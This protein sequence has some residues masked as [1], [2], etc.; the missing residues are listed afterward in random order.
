MLGGDTRFVPGTARSAL[1]HRSFRTLFVGAFLSNI[2]TWMQQVVLG[3]F[4]YELT[5]SA[6][7]LG[8]L[9]FAQLGPTLLLGPVS[10]LIADVV[11]RRKLLIGLSVEQLLAAVALAAI[12]STADPSRTAMALVV[13]AAGV[14]NS[15]FMPAYSA[16]LPALV[17]RDDLAGAI[18]LNSAQLNASRVIGPAIGGIAYAAVGPG[19]V[20]LANALS[21]L[22]VIAAVARVAMPAV[23]APDGERGW[24]KLTLGFRVAR[25]DR[26]V[27]RALVTITAFSFFSLLWVGQMPVVAAENLGIDEDSSAYG[28]FYG[29]FG[30]GA[31]VGSLAIGTVFARRSNA[32]LVRVG[33]VV[34]AA[35]LA[36][37][38][39]LRSPTLAYPTVLLVGATYFG[40]ITAL[41]TAMQSRLADNERGRVM[42]LWMMG[43]GGTVALSNL[44]F[45]PVIDRI[46]MRPVMLFGAVVAAVLGWRVAD[47]R[48]PEERDA[49]AVDPVVGGAADLATGGAATDAVQPPASRAAATRSSPA[50]R[51]ALIRTASPSPSA[52]NA[53]TAS[54]T[55]P[56][57]AT[58]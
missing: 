27:G 50:T 23:P 45:G 11:D 15:V 24:R 56:T 14:G 43:F 13:L 21:Y 41:N 18:S 2:G 52:P 3:A 28:F 19:W 4:A 25:T 12:V 16:L 22:F 57:G 26:V 1:A 55:P 40:A 44:V 36:A 6:T 53:R 30:V 17:G 47:V 46:G 20:F 54:S 9:V 39:L 33:L 35:L 32:Q 31:V 5:G 48:T 49:G 29:A 38:A 58:P 10:G 7:F 51:L 34:Y 42:G 8:V 37:F